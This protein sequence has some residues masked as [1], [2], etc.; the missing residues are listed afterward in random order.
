M[1]GVLSDDVISSGGKPM[2]AHW[3]FMWKTKQSGYVV[4]KAIRL[5][6]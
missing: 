6:L 2:S 4:N 1:T 5:E 3:I